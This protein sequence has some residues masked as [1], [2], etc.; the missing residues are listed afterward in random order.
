MVASDFAQWLATIAC[1]IVRRGFL[2]SFF[3]SMRFDV[4]ALANCVVQV[5]DDCVRPGSQP[6]DTSSMPSRTGHR[7]PARPKKRPDGLGMPLA[8]AAA[9]LVRSMS[10]YT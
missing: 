4:S 5:G 10:I 3:F 1:V 8:L 2:S 9:R 7:W 6:H